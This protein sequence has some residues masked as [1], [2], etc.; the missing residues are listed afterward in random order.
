MSSCELIL[1]KPNLANNNFNV[2]S[3]EEGV[4]YSASQVFQDIE[5]IKL[6]WNKNL[7]ALTDI[8]Q[9]EDILLQRLK[10]YD[11]KKIDKAGINKSLLDIQKKKGELE[12]ECTRAQFLYSMLNSTLDGSPQEEILYENRD[13]LITGL[14]AWLSDKTS[15]ESRDEACENILKAFDSKSTSLDLSELFLSSLPEEIALLQ[16]LETINLSKN[17]FAA[18]PSVLSKLPHLEEVNLSDNHVAVSS[19]R[20]IIA[21]ILGM[22]GF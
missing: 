21:T 2:I 13:S 6:I 19:P 3:A 7:V 18:M 15:F 11:V 22:F 17:Q 4:T 16:D 20:S 5:E 8:S 9:K 14:N 12:R 10:H 1:S